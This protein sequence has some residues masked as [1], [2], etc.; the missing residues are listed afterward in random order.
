[1][2]MTREVAIHFAE[3]G[4]LEILQK[5]NRIDPNEIIKGPIRLRLLADDNNHSVDE[6]E[7]EK[8]V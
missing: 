1:M 4:I 6:T 3:E 2:P 5:G 8:E 7:K